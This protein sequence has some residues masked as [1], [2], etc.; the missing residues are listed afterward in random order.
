MSRTSLGLPTSIDFS[1]CPVHDSSL[2]TMLAR[3]S[4][5]HQI[6]YELKVNPPF[7]VIPDSGQLAP[8]ESVQIEVRFSPQL[9]KKYL[10]YKI[11]IFI[12]GM[13]ESHSI[14]VSSILPQNLVFL[15]CYFLVKLQTYYT[16]KKKT[17]VT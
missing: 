10:N 13:K 11:D 15:I 12:N 2:R 7:S 17:K 6:H 16:Q 5:S 9:C 3:N 14:D 1:V 8:E 4:A